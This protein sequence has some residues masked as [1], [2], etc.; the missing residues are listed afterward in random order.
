MDQDIPSARR[1]SRLPRQGFTRLD[2]SGQP[3]SREVCRVYPVV[4]ERG[5][6]EF[7]G[8]WGPST[9]AGF[10]VLEAAGVC[11]YLGY[12]YGQDHSRAGTGHHGAT[13]ELG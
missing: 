4:Y 9:A 8:R 7:V 1:E 10:F 13:A 11:N 2:R 6:V 5:K 12:R 3:R